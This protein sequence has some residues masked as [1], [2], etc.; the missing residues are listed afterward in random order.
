MLKHKKKIKKHIDKKILLRARIFAL[1][2]LVMSVLLARDVIIDV[3]SL[4]AAL[5]ALGFG[6]IVGIIAS[7][8]FHLS[9]S[10]D[11]NKV[12]AS[13][14]TLGIIIL[15][16]Y[17]LFAFVRDDILNYIVHGKLVGAMSMALVTGSFLGQLIGMRNGIKGILKEEGIIA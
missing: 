13:L 5:L 16:L 4:P 9:W 1:V 12:I 10:R 17:I 7:R 11:G 3:I 2:F 14:D 15:L 6:L 8:M